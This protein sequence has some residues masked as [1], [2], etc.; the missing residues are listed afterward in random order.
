MDR[1]SIPFCWF[2]HKNGY[3]QRQPGTLHRQHFVRMC[4]RYTRKYRT[5]VLFLFSFFGFIAISKIRSNA[6]EE[7]DDKSFRNVQIRKEQNNKWVHGSR[8]CFKR[9]AGGYNHSSLSFCLACSHS[10]CRMHAFCSHL[11]AFD[12]TFWCKNSCRSVSGHPVVVDQR[13]FLRI[14]AWFI[15]CLL[16]LLF[17]IPQNKGSSPSENVSAYPLI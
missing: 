5:H 8:V 6:W 16:L 12:V 10:L 7:A 9:W 17:P 4:L 11:D 2:V 1:W 15:L 13:P 14:L 3:G